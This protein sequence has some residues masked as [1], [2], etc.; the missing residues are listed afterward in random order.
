VI[1]KPSAFR[2]SFDGHNLATSFVGFDFANGMSIVEAVDVPPDR[3]DVDPEHSVAS[4]ATP[5]DQTL[6][7]I[8]GERV[9]EGVK[10]WRDLN[11]LRA[12]PGVPKLA[13]RF[14]FDYW[15]ETKYRDGA[16]D[17]ERAFRYGLTD[18]A[19]V[20]H[21]WQRWGY[22][23]HLPDVFPPDPARGTLEDFAAMVRTC[24]D[25]DVLFAPHDNYIDFYP[26]SG[27]FSYSNIL[28][29]PDGTPQKAWFHYARQAQSYRARPDRL[30]PFVERNVKL[31]KDGFAPTAYFIDVWSSAAPM[32]YWTQDGRFMDRLSTRAAWGHA[33]DWIRDYLGGA[34]QISEAGHDQLIGHLDG[35]QA[36]QL[37]VEPKGGPGFS[38]TWRINAADSERIP[39]F[40]AAHHDR[41]VLHGAGYP[42]RYAAGLPEEMHGIYSDDYIATEVLTGRPAMVADL[43][44]RDVVRKYWL[45]HDLMR[46]LALR[47]MDGFEFAGSVHRE[48]VRWEQGG[49]ISVNRGRQDWSTA[50]HVLPQYGYYAR[51]PVEKGAVE[52]AVER[53]DGKTYEWS[54]SPSAI[55]INGRGNAVSVAGVTTSGGARVTY[56]GSA[57]V[58]TPLPS[59][60]RVS[61]AL[62]LGRLP[63]KMAMPTRIEAINEQGKVIHVSRIRKGGDEVTVP[64]EPDV[65]AYR[66]RAKS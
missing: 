11:G 20:W 27:G 33:F 34:P 29:N 5:H 46:A 8:P 6:T 55:Y 53:K 21:N 44:S 48:H 49:D 18:A 64:C 23:Y 37:R 45:L 12:A 50:E 60:G 61:V 40:D 54:Q 28:F 52:S 15:G 43:F 66:L 47:K 36:N 13:G 58:V 42:D 4:L 51:V 10:A 16:K 9:W 62:A 35:A 65:F 56:E 41:F 2:L 26:D 59:S 30:Q 32:D 31:I 63:W 7:F 1:V 25:H 17:L 3:L 39:W 19:V 14:V 38:F 57:I 22:D 24:K